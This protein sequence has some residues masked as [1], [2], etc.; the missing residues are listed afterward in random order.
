MLQDSLFSLF[1]T[2]SSASAVCITSYKNGWYKWAG[3]ANL[4]LSFKD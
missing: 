2:G 3:G 4:P 1:I